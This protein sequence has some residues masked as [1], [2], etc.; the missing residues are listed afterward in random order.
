MDALAI[1]DVTLTP[2]RIIP[3]DLGAVYHGLKSTESS[4]QGFG[5]AYFSNVAHK[6]VKGWKLHTKMISN[7]IV[8]IGAIRFVLYDARPESET[9]GQIMDVILSLENY[10]R[11]TIPPGIWMAFQGVSAGQNMLLNISSIPHDP[12]E[13]IGLPLNTTEIPFQQW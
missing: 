13:S 9:K 1:K 4:F 7:L 11:L 8:P 3:G 10:Q 12:T 6:A 2:L 5:E